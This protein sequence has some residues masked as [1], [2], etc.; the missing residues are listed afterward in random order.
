MA[1][2]VIKAELR[3]KAGKGSSRALRREDKIP[4]VIYGD[5]KGPVTVTISRIDLVKQLNTGG[6]L[7]TSYE[8]Q[9][10]KDKETVLPRDVQFHP[11]TD[12][13]MHV[14]F[15]RLAKGSSLNIMIPI[16]FVGEEVSPGIK[17]GGILNVVRHEVEFSCPANAI[18]EAIEI[19][20]SEVEMN[21][22]IH[23]STVTLPKGVTPVID[24]RD[25][26]I[27]TIS[28]PSG[29][30][31]ADSGDEDEGETAEAEAT[32]GDEE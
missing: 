26:T 1:S 10:G 23:I 5:K 6:F 4:A 13:P 32:E 15:F 14:D 2:P 7:N 24:D 29:L 19:D 27:A 22:S 20:I 12:W 16:H 17:A 31:S 25:F 18:P 8:I 28:A 30:K 11:V 21:E 3:E 9:I